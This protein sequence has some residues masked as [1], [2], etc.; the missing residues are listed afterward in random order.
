[1]AT[2]AAAAAGSG[3]STAAS[4]ATREIAD[5]GAQAPPDERLHFALAAMG[6]GAGFLVSKGVVEVALK[7]LGISG[8]QWQR[9]S[10][11]AL[12][13]LHP[14]R[15]AVVT[16]GQG[17]ALGYVG[18]VH[19][20]TAAAYGL[21]Q[22]AAVAEIDLV[23]AARLRPE[24][25]T[26]RPWPKAPAVRR[27]LA[28]VLPETVPAA[29]VVAVMRRAGAPLLADCRLFDTYAGE[30]IASGARSLAYTLVY[31]A[32]RTLTDAEVDRCH[33]AVREALQ[34]ELGAQLRS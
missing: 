10:S 28:L 7:R 2:G 16:A 14:G 32:E 34:E 29:D 13:Y 9:A 6:T 3:T 33:Q 31:Q 27:D 15:S 18:E 17:I 20:E 1:M 23:A 24:R 11:S 25:V 22:P 21:A 4:A 26:Y 30:G 5:G 8:L 19:P 12:P